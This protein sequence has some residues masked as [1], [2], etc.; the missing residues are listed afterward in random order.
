MPDACTR[1]YVHIVWATWD[2]IPLITPD[3]EAAIYAVIA[4]KYQQLQCL[5]IAIGGIEDHVHLLV[6]LHPSASVST[7][8]KEVKGASSH[9]VITMLMPGH[10][11]RWQGGYGAFT[12][13]PPDTKRVR[14]YVLSQKEHHHSGKLLPLLERCAEQTGKVQEVDS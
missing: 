5:P 4:N 8:V 1:L 7:L 2:R 12:L 9:L 14:S 6:R 13:A 11:F 10:G 3:L